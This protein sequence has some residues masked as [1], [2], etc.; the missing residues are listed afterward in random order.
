M[1]QAES[2]LM[3]RDIREEENLNQS[4]INKSFVVIDQWRQ[5]S[6]AKHL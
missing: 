1:D 2:G 4:L 5:N 6:S 3:F